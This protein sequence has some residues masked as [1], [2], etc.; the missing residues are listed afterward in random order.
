MRM[1]YVR[2][3][4]RYYDLPIN[5]PT[6]SQPIREKTTVAKDWLKRTLSSDKRDFC[7]FVPT[8]D[9]ETCNFF[10]R[11]FWLI[12]ANEGSKARELL[13]K[14]R[15]HLGLEPQCVYAHPLRER[16]GPGG[17]TV[18]SAPAVPNR[19][20]STEASRFEVLAA[21]TSTRA[22]SFRIIK[23]HKLSAALRHKKSVSKPTSP[24]VKDKRQGIARTSLKK[25]ARSTTRGLS[26][27]TDKSESSRS[28]SEKGE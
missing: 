28:V 10:V 26:P 15:R 17:D 11:F 20:P 19:L 4:S 9:D 7:N 14:A 8:L 3:A 25:A 2:A 18:H 22:Y 23:P 27:A 13:R 1:L 12:S 6:H 16:L 24:I 21:P 5:P